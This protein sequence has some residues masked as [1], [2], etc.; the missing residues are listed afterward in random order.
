MTPSAKQKYLTIYLCAAVFWTVLGAL[1]LTAL[2]LGDIQAGR[3]A[4]L[5]WRRWMVFLS[6][7][8]SWAFITAFV[9]W[10]IERDPPGR[11]HWRWLAHMLAAMLAWL[12]IISLIV[13]L[14][15]DLLW[16]DPISSIAVMLGNVPPFLY[17]FNALKFLLTYGACAGIVYYRHLLETKLQLLKLERVAAEAMEK[18]S[19]LELQALQAQLSPHFLFNALNSVSGLARNQDGHAVVEVV[20][21]LADLLR[22]AVE[23]TREPAVL[24]EDE[25]RFTANYVALQQIRFVGGFRYRTEVRLADTHAFCPPFCIQ[26]LVENVF[27]HNELSSTYP[28]D[29]MVG[30]TQAEGRLSVEVANSVATRAD[31]EGTGV[32][33]ANLAG[34]LNLLYGAGADLTTSHSGGCYRAAISFPARVDYD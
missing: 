29:I 19:R 33:L 24:L 27:A 26:T 11:D 15:T 10:L 20:A 25:L 32:G 23:A 13:Q 3:G 12:V 28:I 31:S 18:K 1:H 22:Y 7:Y 2:S 16:R 34:R 21:R 8:C 17:L 14:L 30:I 9:Y 5:S 6:S 4:D